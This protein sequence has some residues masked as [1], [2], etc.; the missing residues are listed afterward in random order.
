ML[1]DS[2][3]VPETN[4][5]TNEGLLCL[6]SYFIVLIFNIKRTSIGYTELLATTRRSVSAFI[7][8]SYHDGKISETTKVRGLFRICMRCWLL[9]PHGSSG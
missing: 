5:E 6:E 2:V 7:D 8:Q 9:L 4:C 3:P 1:T